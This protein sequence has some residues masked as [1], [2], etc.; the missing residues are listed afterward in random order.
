MNSRRVERLARGW[1]LAAF[2]TLVSAFVHVLSGGEMP[3]LLPV[4]LA[5]LIGGTFGAALLGGRVTLWRLSLGALVS[6]TVFHGLFSL[7]TG[8][9]LML[10]AESGLAVSAHAQHASHA[11]VGA[12]LNS[13]PFTGV[14]HGYFDHGGS[15]LV[16]HLVAG[17]FTVG[18]VLYGSQALGAIA[19]AARMVV[20]RLV[21]G[22]LRPVV[23]ADAARMPLT[24]ASVVRPLLSRLLC[25]S[26]TRYRGPPALRAF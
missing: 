21:F 11:A 19:L 3:G 18:A 1:A 10:G 14:A 25:L 8:A 22:R 16:G 6:Q 26:L 2:S 20:G 9:N 23:V 24:P 17:V 7:G 4:A 15:M 12:L 5:L 13:A